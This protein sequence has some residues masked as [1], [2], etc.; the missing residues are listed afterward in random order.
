[1]TQQ[2]PALYVTVL[3][4]LFLS[5]RAV[6]SGRVSARSRVGHSWLVQELMGMIAYSYIL[7]LINKNIV[8]N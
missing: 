1:M 2:T 3:F 4:G 7:D 8:P 6:S 5:A